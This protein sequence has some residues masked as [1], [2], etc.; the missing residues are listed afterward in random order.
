MAE[1]ERVLYLT[2]AEEKEMKKVIKA[3][4]L[5]AKH[6]PLFTPTGYDFPMGDNGVI[7]IQYGPPTMYGPFT[8]SVTIRK[9]KIEH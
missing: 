4:R 3:L 8:G 6:D 5:L 7:T 9:D 1:K 2:K